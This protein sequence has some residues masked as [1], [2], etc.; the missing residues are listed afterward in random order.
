MKHGGDTRKIHG[1]MLDWD[2]WMRP[3]WRECRSWEGTVE[4]YNFGQERHFQQSYFSEPPHFSS[5]LGFVA[6][7]LG[8]LVTSVVYHLFSFSPC[9]W[10]LKFLHNFMGSTEHYCYAVEKILKFFSRVFLLIWGL[11]L[12]KKKKSGFGFFECDFLSAASSN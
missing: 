2:T 8:I 9:I 12:K 5:V 3:S 11:C 4:Q 10:I 6:L 1:S 7:A